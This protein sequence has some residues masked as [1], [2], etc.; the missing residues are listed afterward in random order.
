MTTQ[1]LHSIIDENEEL[2]LR[3]S[4][5]EEI[6]KYMEAL[7]KRCE[8][9]EEEKGRFDLQIRSLIEKNSLLEK[10]LKLIQENHRE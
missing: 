9:L 4:K 8:E 5:L 10:E 3:V 7:L 1:Y 2:R 6:Q